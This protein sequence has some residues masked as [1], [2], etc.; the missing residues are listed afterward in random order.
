MRV[1]YIC[2]L[3]EI[4]TR[5]IRRSRRDNRSSELFNELTGRQRKVTLCRKA[6]NFR[7]NVNEETNE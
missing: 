7:G 1:V 4:S 2:L 6:T 3:D 5:K